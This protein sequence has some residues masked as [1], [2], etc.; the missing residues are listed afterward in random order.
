MFPVAYIDHQ[1]SQ[2]LQAKHNLLLLHRLDWVWI[3]QLIFTSHCLRFCWLNKKHNTYHIKG[4]KVT[5]HK[6]NK[7]SHGSMY[8]FFPYLHYKEVR[9]HQA[10][11]KA[12]LQW[13]NV[14]S[15]PPSGTKLMLH[16]MLLELYQRITWPIL[17]EKRI[18]FSFSFFSSWLGR[19]WEGVH[20]K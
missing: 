10:R 18:S 1:G 5:Y 7:D 6:L 13:N 16:L 19:G 3:L 8:I 17:L 11:H 20:E 15:L 12:K 4:K 9:E 2:F 14:D